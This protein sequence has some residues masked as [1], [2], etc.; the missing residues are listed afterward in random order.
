MWFN[1]V[2]DCL[3]HFR[4]EPIP[5]DGDSSEARLGDYV[6]KFPDA[7]GG[8]GEG[9]GGGSAMGF[10]WPAGNVGMALG[11]ILTTRVTAQAATQRTAGL[12]ATATPTATAGTAASARSSSGSNS[13]RSSG[14]QNLPE[15][16][17]VGVQKDMSR[18]TQLRLL[19]HV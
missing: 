14:V 3:E 1:S 2:F 18:L 19:L 10:S 16:N 7:S 17:E 5:V 15:P 6:V 8:S 12:T 4:T 13:N 11:G 9:G